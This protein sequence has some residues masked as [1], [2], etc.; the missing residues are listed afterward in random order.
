MSNARNL[1]DIVTGNFDVPLGALD[2][3]Q[4]TPAAISDQANASTGYLALPAGTTAQ[5]PVSP[6]N[7]MTRYNTTTGEPEWYDAPGEDW[8][9]FRNAPT[10][11]IETL[12]VA[13]GASGSRTP[14]TSSAGGGGAGGLLSDSTTIEIGSEFP[15][16]IG[17]GGAAYQSPLDGGGN[18]GSNTTA[19]NL[20]T[21]GGG[22]GGWYNGT[23][24]YQ[25]AR[26]GGSGGGA[27]WNGSNGTTFGA[28]TF[29]QGNNG[30]NAS[31]NGASCGGG[32]G[33]SGAVGG[34]APNNSIGGT[35]GAGTNWQSLGTFYAG[36][37]GG[38][39]AGSARAPGG[40]GGGG[41]GGFG[42]VTA[43]IT[44]VAGSVNTGGGG[45]GTGGAGYGTTG[46]RPSGAGGSGIVIIR[47]E[48]SQRGTGG[49]VTSAGGY[50]YHTFTS[51]GT[52]TT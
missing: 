36:G 32:G 7:G 19:F 25:N 14:N 9:S 44:G 48:G 38:G 39:S 37:G 43:D 40:T 47:Y 20:E 18:A 3:V 42:T 26:S 11:T 10:Y 12:V 45:G 51:S 46:T 16:V 34:N 33:G 49:T 31:P 17:A 35:G 41:A 21:I 4:V 15:I 24:G 13:G 23:E 30:G 50:T 27:S 6:V 2:N 52:F 8:V 1:A 22:T 29:G 28:G 5:R